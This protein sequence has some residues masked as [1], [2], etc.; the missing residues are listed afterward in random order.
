MISTVPTVLQRQGI[1]TESIGGRVPAIYD[2][3]TTVPAAG[4]GVTRSPF[5]GNAIPADRIDAV[6]RTLLERYPLPTAAGTGN[7]YRRAA[8]ERVDQDQFSLRLDSSFSTRD[9]AFARLTRFHEEFSPVTP[10]PDGSGVTSGTLG[11]QATTSWS[12]ASS[13]QR[14]FSSTLLNELRI[15]DTRR[16][17]RRAAAELPTNASA[18]LGL[19]GI[20]ST[21][22]FPNTLPTFLVAGYQQLGSPPNTA[23][24]FST[25]VTQLP[26]PSR[27]SQGGTPSGWVETC[28]G[29]AWTCCSRP[30]RQVRSRSA[31]CSAICRARRTRAHRSRA[32]CSGRCSNFRSTFSR[33]RSA[34]AL[35]SR[36]TSSRTTGARSIV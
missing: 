19:P 32:F 31:T 34:T 16:T 20:P 36:S 5:P 15:G 12:V 4:G 29:S 10:L 8:D 35:A 13:Y 33:R 7:N 6:A 17:V 25:S 3:A 9:R 1:F 24:D 27:G 22:Q 2:P 26:I 11:P 18:A 21:A 30:R 14:T 28:A 23:T